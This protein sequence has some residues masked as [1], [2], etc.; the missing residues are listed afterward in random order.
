MLHDAQVGVVSGTDFGGWSD[1]EIRGF[2]DQ[3]GEDYNDCLDREALVRGG[4]VGLL[5]TG[6]C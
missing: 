5:C 2:L 3:R 6:R 1:A 4:V